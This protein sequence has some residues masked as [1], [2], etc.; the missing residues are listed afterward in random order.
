M[1]KQTLISIIIFALIWALLHF[2]F[3]IRFNGL[4]KFWLLGIYLVIHFIADL[5]S[6]DIIQEQE[7][8][9][10]KNWPTS[11]PIGK[12]GQNGL[13]FMFYTTGLLSFINPFQLV[14]IIKQAIGNSAL[15]ANKNELIEN[16][17]TYQN[18]TK[19][20]LPFQKNTEWLVYN[21]G[22]TQQSSHSWNVIT[23]RFA[24]DF[25]IAD[26]NYFRHINKGTNLEDYFCFNQNIV[27][28]ADGTI[29][30]TINSKR[31]A[32]LVGYGILDFLTTSFIGNYVIIKHT[33]NEYS[34]YA[35]LNKG[36]ITVVA[37][38]TV[39]QGQIIGQCGHSGYSSEP[40]LHFHLQNKPD[41]F[42]AKGLPIKFSNIMV[43]GIK[44]S[45]TFISASDKVQNI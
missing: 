14:Q 31:N 28:V 26:K 42:K 24:Y 36:S 25:V 5:I 38:D 9:K 33:D 23:Q 2:I 34:F 7:N 27:A 44:Q 30:K 10:F 32:L 18:E 19:Y 16:A 22:T 21:G 41:F 8:E 20:I 6:K 43:N 12:L 37:G 39:T 15:K 11:G 17:E 45:E 29:I 3:K 40:H 4:H 13:L 35:H 1:K